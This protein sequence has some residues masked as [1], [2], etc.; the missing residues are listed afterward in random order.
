MTDN[1]E[2]IEYPY[3]L[4]GIE[5]ADPLFLWRRGVYCVDEMQPLPP[6]LNAALNQLGLIVA[7]MVSKPLPDSAIHLIALAELLRQ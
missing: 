7:G 4:Q 3:N 6:K 5:P 2:G 1:L